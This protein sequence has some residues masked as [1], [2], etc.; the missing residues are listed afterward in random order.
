[1]RGLMFQIMGFKFPILLN[2]IFCVLLGNVSFAQKKKELSENEK[3][4]T[5]YIFKGNEEITKEKANFV[6]AEKLY[7]K[8]IAEDTKNA[9]AKYNLGVSYHA[10]KNYQEAAQR[11]EQAAKLAK[12]EG[13]KH[14]SYHNLGNSYMGTGEFEKAIEAYKN[15]LRNNPTDHET[16]YNLALAKKAK[17]QQDKNKP[18]DNKD[19]KKEEGDN[20]DKKEDSSQDKKN[21]DGNK[22]DQKEDKKDDKSKEEGDKEEDKK[23]EDKEGDKDESD[24]KEGD[25]KDDKKPKPVPGK[26]SPEQVKSLL[27]AMENQEKKIQ[28]KVNAKKVKGTPVR[29]EKDW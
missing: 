27:Q 14:A 26:L 9:K 15:A 18:Q 10:T 5:Q 22:E 6:E 1:M 2:L 25:K 13:E 4:A 16:R 23:N 29:S 8:A 21:E 12:N 11:S 17:K 20:K 19:N 3:K 24:D 7:R 28:D